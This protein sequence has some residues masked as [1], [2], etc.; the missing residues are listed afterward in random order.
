MGLNTINYESHSSNR[1]PQIETII[2]YDDE[3]KPIQSRQTFT[4]DQTKPIDYK[5][6]QFSATQ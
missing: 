5:P 2:P 6:Y 3:P 1:E 4:I